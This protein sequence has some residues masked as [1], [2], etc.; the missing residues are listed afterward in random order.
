VFDGSHVDNDEVTVSRTAE[1][2][3]EAD[4]YF[5]VYADGDHLADL[6]ATVRVIRGALRVI[7]PA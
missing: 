1:L 7:V 2:S 5:A 4:R 3:I 6:P